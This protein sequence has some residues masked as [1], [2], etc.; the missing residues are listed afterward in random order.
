MD[1]LGRTR[2]RFLGTLAAG[3]ALHRAPFAQAVEA[4]ADA[5]GVGG[6]AAKAVTASSGGSAI[7]AARG[8]L[9]GHFVMDN[10]FYKSVMKPSEQAALTK[11]LGYTGMTCSLGNQWEQF[12]DLVRELDRQQ[13]ALVG[14]NTGL[15]IH[16]EPPPKRLEKLIELLKGRPTYL[17]L[18]LRSKQDSRGSKS[19]D[20]RAIELLKQFC[21]LCARHEIAGVALYPYF[22]NWL[23]TVSHGVRLCKAV[24]RPN[25]STMFNQYHWMRTERRLGL[26]ATLALA[27]PHLRCVTV[28][29][30]DDKEPDVRPLGSGSYDTASILKQLAALKYEGEVGSF[31]HG[32]EGDIPGQLESSMNGWRKLRKQL[33]DAR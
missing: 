14:I 25:L 2:R 16:G 17:M 18:Q 21:D 3:A 4:L 13:L 12:P 8:W 28:N 7:P 22:G 1:G 10:W 29:G 26:D 20:G 19:G 30:S 32:V 9:A 24:D 15:F 11:R 5:R 33:G 27:L 23:E 6:G 31:G